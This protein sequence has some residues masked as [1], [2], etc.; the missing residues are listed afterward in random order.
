MY[1]EK[2]Q[3]VKAFVLDVDGVLTD[4]GILVMENGDLL[5]TMNIKD[6][7]ALG[8]AVKAGFTIIVISGGTSEGVRIR[9][10]KLGIKEV[11][12]AV[13]NKRAILEARLNALNLTLGDC[14]IMGDDVPDIEILSLAGCSACPA[15]AVLQVRENIDYLATLEGGK[16]CVREVIEKVMRLDNSW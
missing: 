15:D 13:Q 9:L 16:G 8:R 12:L 5:R 7:Y 6:G 4:G 10:N 3:K 14:L 2:F 11:H 1:L